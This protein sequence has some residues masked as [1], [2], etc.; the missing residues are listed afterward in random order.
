MIWISTD[1]SYLVEF[2]FAESFNLLPFTVV[3]SN[4]LATK[5]ASAFFALTASTTFSTLP[6]S[7]SATTIPVVTITKSVSFCLTT[8]GF[9][10]GVD[11]FFFVN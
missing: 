6:L 9:Y 10:F 8:T 7:A 1:P 2:S 5:F 11:F 4:S 3:T